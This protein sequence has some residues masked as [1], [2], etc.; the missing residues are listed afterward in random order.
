MLERVTISQACV[1]RWAGAVGLEFLFP[2]ATSYWETKP[3]TK[4]GK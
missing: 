2:R 4:R 3:L 1:Q